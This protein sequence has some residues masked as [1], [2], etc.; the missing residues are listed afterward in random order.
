MRT[1]IGVKSQADTTV[2]LGLR[3]YFNDVFSRM[4][5][6]MLVSAFFAYIGLRL[7]FLYAGGILTWTIIL[8]PLAF[9]IAMSFGAARFSNRGLLLMLMG[10]AAAQGLSMG[11]LLYIYTAHS[12]I[13]AFLISAIVFGTFAIIGYTTRRDLSGLGTFLF[14]GLIGIVIASIVNIWLKMTAVAFVVNVLA[15]LIFTGLTAYD[16]QKLKQIYQEGADSSKT[17]TLG[18]LTLYLDFINIFV[19]IL[20]LLGSKRD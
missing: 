10:F 8:S 20:Q 12:V 4:T 16:M 5:T 11:A 15:V 14:V 6:A 9:V 19:S 2:D 18:A 1:N 13:S 17:R 3:A 7:P